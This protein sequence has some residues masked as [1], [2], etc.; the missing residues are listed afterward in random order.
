MP[1]ASLAETL[2]LRVRESAGRADKRP[3][4]IVAAGEKVVDKFVAGILAAADG[5]QKALVDEVSQ[6]DAS[7]CVL[8]ITG[9][10]PLAT[11]TNSPYLSRARR[12]PP[13]RSAR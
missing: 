1:I 7:F 10:A 12:C 13:C 6:A 4:V 2:G 3:T 5:G 8:A 11:E 9:G